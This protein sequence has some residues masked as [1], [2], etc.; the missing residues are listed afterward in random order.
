LENSLLKF[1]IGAG[2]RLKIA[3]CHACTCYGNV[4]T[5]VDWYGKSKWSQLNQRPQYLPGDLGDWEKL[6][7]ESLI[8]SSYK[9]GTYEA[10]DWFVNTSLSQLGGHPTWIQDA[11]YPKC[12]SCATLMQ[13][14]G[15][16]D[17]GDMTRY[18]EGV[19][20]AFLCKPCGMACTHY[21]QT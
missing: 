8:M 16:V 4:Y 20:Y 19:Y 14:I 2:S 1:L 5:N 9:R 7:P 15:Q 17:V 6:A 3:T 18:G 11:E 10:A 21:Q 12:I 13:F